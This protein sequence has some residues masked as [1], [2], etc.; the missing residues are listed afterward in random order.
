MEQEKQPIG[1]LFDSIA[2][3]KPEDVSILTDNLTYEQSFYVLTQALE[4]AYKANLY[5]L[6]ESELVSKSLRILN[7]P[8]TE[9]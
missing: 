6:Q 9:E 7:S 5:S 8:K 2:Y 1:L 3:Y 4:F